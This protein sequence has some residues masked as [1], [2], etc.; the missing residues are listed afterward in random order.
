[1]SSTPP[2]APHGNTAN[3]A[4]L[5]A[6]IAAH[7]LVVGDN[8]T[9]LPGLTLYRRIAQTPCYQAMYEPSVTLFA[10]GHKRI[11]L[12][13]VDHD[14]TAGGFLISSVDLPVQSQVIEATPERPLLSMLLALDVRI[15]REVLAGE[16][17]PEPQVGA[18]R[19]G[20]ALGQA[21][22]G[23]VSAC[24][25]LVGLLDT[26]GDIAFLGPLIQ[27]EILFCLLQT[28]QAGRLRAI[29]SASDSSH[30]IARAIAWMRGN[31]A[32]P[33]RIEALAE[34]ARMGVS[35]LHHQFRALTAMSPIQYQKQM[36]LQAARERMVGG[37]DATSAAFA[38]GY[39]SV[40]Q[41]N[42]EYARLFGQP[43]LRDIK[44]IKQA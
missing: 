18:D 13:G 3:L 15:L 43:P 22:G 29:A 28:P 40:S 11:N 39:E 1:M 36:R 33:L 17:V 2:A 8:V 27:R 42:R 23:L 30:R 6:A 44:A 7:T 4:G 21:P 5:V 19:L 32:E 16:G 37:M 10:Q 12:G 24:I 34:M 25:R 26:P 31:Y 38:V 35:T 41:F 14:G 20:I 9:L